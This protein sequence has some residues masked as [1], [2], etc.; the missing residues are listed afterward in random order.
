VRAYIVGHGSIAQRHIRNILDVAPETQL[1]VQRPRSGR[2]L[3][4][5]TSVTVVESPDDAIALGIDYAVIASASADHVQSLV[6]L[7]QAGIP[8]YIEKP[9]VTTRAEMAA[10]REAIDE[11]RYS[12]PTLVGCNL[13]FLPSLVAARDALRDGAIGRIS[14]AQLEA[15]QWLPDWRPGRDYRTGYSARR[16]QGGGV[17]LDLIHE[18]DAARW[19]LGEFDRVQADLG[20]RSDLDLDSEDTAGVLMSSAN[21]PLVVAS[22]DYVSRV[23]V[24]RYSFVGDRGTLVWDL[25]E[26]TLTLTTPG[27]TNVLTSDPAKFDVQRTYIEA[28]REF[29]D[30]VQSATETS[31]PIHDGLSSLDLA[32]RVKESQQ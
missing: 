29:L 32:L 16:D 27:E 30:A 18:L 1:V 26:R 25:S 3:D 13:R 5:T 12:A 17:V 4:L 23:P 6:P 31:Q 24:R 15:G 14:R 9:V 28:M 22:L 20:Q 10:V 7:I 11:S 2:E 21:G 19:M 8:L